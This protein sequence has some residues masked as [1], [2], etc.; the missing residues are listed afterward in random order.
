M[1]RIHNKSQQLKAELIRR[2]RNLDKRNHRKYLSSTNVFCLF[3]LKAEVDKHTFNFFCT[4]FG[5]SIW[6][7]RK[8]P[9]IVIPCKIEFSDTGALWLSTP[10]RNFSNPFQKNL[11]IMEGHFLLLMFGSYI[12]ILFPD[13]ITAYDGP[14]TVEDI[15]KISEFIKMYRC[16]VL[17]WKFPFNKIFTIASE[18]RKFWLPPYVFMKINTPN[19]EITCKYFFTIRPWEMYLYVHIFYFQVLNYW[20]KNNGLR[21]SNINFNQ[22]KIR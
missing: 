11:S 16:V 8:N 14:V 10:H 13:K 21:F 15:V 22:S 12:F 1:L 9:R 5:D 18:L 17:K 20:R 19:F 3:Q 4:I 6:T 2:E 7:A